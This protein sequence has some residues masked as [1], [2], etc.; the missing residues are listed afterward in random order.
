MIAGK[1]FFQ[2]LRLFDT[3]GVTFSAKVECV[4]SYAPTQW[5]T[6]VGVNSCLTCKDAQSSCVSFAMNSVPWS[7]TSVLQTPNVVNNR[8]MAFATVSA[9][10]FLIGKVNKYLENVSTAVKTYVSTSDVGGKRSY[11]SISHISKGWLSFH[12]SKFGKD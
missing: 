7:L 8:K 4:C 5:C 12:N 1:K 6:K 2:E 9:S 3:Y 10:L 11:K